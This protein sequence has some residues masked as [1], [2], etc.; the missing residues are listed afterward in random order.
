LHVHRFVVGLNLA[1]TLCGNLVVVKFRVA[2]LSLDVLQ[3][4]HAANEGHVTNSLRITNGNHITNSRHATDRGH[5]PHREHLRGATRT[6]PGGSALG[7]HQQVDTWMT[8]FLV[9]LFV[10]DGVRGVA[11]RG[12]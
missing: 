6:P 8:E 9:N 5:S 1:T 12:T 10:G 11:W 2:V 3:R 4:R 7:T